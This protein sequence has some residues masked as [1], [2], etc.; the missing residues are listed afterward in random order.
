MSKQKLAEVA[1]KLRPWYGLIGKVAFL[2]VALFILFGV[3]FGF[4][5]MSDI[6]MSPIVNDG[7]LMLFSRI[8]NDYSENDVVIY[9]HDGKTAVSRVIAKED[10]IIDI[11]E[12]GYL[13]VDGSIV[14]KGPVTT[15]IDTAGTQYGLPYRVPSKQVYLLND[16]YE[17]KE[18]SRSFGAIFVEKLQ[19]KI[20]S[21][22]KV[23][24]I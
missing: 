15:E 8:G 12:D 7:D 5:R 23:R 18:D 14:S 2:L 17:M 6:A 10:Q 1:A 3:V 11:N 20:I 13:T 9:E 21:V 22:L 4:R 16:N 19:G 24:G